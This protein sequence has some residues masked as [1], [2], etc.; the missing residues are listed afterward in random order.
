M[1]LACWTQS[2]LSQQLWSIFNALNNQEPFVPTDIAGLSFWFDA[3]NGALNSISPNTPATQGQTVRRWLDLSGN[4]LNADQATGAN[5]TILAKLGAKGNYFRQS[6]DLSNAAWTVANGA[7]KSAGITGPNGETS[8]QVSFGAASD[9]VLHQVGI[10]P[11]LTTNKIYTLFVWARAVSG[12]T[13]F[14]LQ[15]GDIVTSAQNATETWTL[16]SITSGPGN[17][18]SWAY[19]ARNNAAGNTS[20]M[21]IGRSWLVENT[22]SPEYVPTTTTP[23]IPN[24]A[25]LPNALRFDGANDALVIASFARNIEVT[26]FAVVENYADPAIANAIIAE[27]GTGALTPGQ[28]VQSNGGVVTCLNASNYSYFVSSSPVPAPQF[29]QRIISWRCNIANIAKQIRSNGNILTGVGATVLGTPTNVVINATMNIGSRNNGGSFVLNGVIASI[30]M[31][32][33]IL[34][35][36]EILQVEAYLKNEFQIP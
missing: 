22:W 29:S 5:Q 36:A 3:N 23:V 8:A 2:P 18:A 13:T 6:N 9:S 33:R 12:A 19:V 10:S 26:L 1:S 4:N 35:D 24:V 20:N 16:Y 30:M 7:S 17:N 21:Y 28:G 25:A 11:I 34:S 32:N 31:Y 15:I 27:G 14:R